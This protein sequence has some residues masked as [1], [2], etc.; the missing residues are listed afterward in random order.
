MGGGKLLIYRQIVDALHCVRQLLAAKTQ[1]C[2]SI[3]VSR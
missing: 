1:S 3:I 2:K